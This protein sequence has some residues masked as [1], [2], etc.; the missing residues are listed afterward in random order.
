MR[1]R[2]ATQ[3]NNGAAVRLY[4][5]HIDIGLARAA[6]RTRPGLRQVLPA[7]AGSNTLVR[8]A[9]RF[10]IGESAQHALPLLG[11]AGLRLHRLIQR[12]VRTLSVVY[13]YRVLHTHS[14]TFTVGPLHDIDAIPFKH[15]FRDK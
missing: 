4:F 13:S 14:H 11:A 8:H 3:A 2:Q 7:R 12:S 10:V 1:A 9:E 5:N 15:E 6:I